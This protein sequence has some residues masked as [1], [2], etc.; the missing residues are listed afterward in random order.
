MAKH[1]VPYHEKKLGQLFC[2]NKSSDILELLLA[3][4]AE[5]GAQIRLDT[6]V[7]SIEKPQAVSCCKATSAKWPASH[8]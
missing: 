3:E 6:A 4:C 7:H 2:D 5:A 8:W 1:G